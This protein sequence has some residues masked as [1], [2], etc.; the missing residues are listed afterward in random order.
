[1]ED[2]KEEEKPLKESCMF[3]NIS[4]PSTRRNMLTGQPEIHINASSV[5]CMRAECPFGL[6]LVKQ[7]NCFIKQVKKEYEEKKGVM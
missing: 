6:W 5:D 4:I 1:V 7:G 3:I 2:K